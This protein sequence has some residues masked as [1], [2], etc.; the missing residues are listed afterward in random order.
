MITQQIVRSINLG[1]NLPAVRLLIS[2]AQ[3]S[4]SSASGEK[5]DSSSSSAQKSSTQDYKCPEYFEHNEAT[6][7]DL[8]LDMMKCRQPQPS[9]K[10]PL[11]K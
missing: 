8:H 9:S 1:K 11:S 4:S 3:S 5:T 6:F 2:R 10:E 7:Y